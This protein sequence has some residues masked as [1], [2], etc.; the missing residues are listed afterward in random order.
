MRSGGVEMRATHPAALLAL[1]GL[2]GCGTEPSPPPP[3]LAGKIIFASDRNAPVSG[4]AVL[5]TMNPDGSDIRLL[6][7]PLPPPL[8]QADVAPSGDRL[9]FVRDGIYVVNADGTALRHPL[10]DGAPVRPRWS[11][12][13]KRL[14]YYARAGGSLSNDLWV[15]NADGSNPVDLTPT[16]TEEEGVGNWS[17][18]GARLVYFRLPTDGSV[19]D[20]LWIVNADGTMPHQVATDA[21]I[22]ADWPA[23][24]P[25]GAWI[26]YVGGGTQIRV[27]RPDG[28]DDRLVFDGGNTGVLLPS[29]SPDGKTL[30]FVYFTAIATV[31]A[32]GTGFRVIADSADNSDPVWGPALK[33]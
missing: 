10:P 24:S 14:A 29:W 11:P 21:A 26:A 9:A 15:A 6:P 13:G 19:P 27:V 7:I 3:P 30:A 12:D 5:Y 25:D 28:T 20:Q 23:F 2:A 18:D 31:G 8:G 4:S 33:P 22:S 32:D 1:A 17:P 16:A